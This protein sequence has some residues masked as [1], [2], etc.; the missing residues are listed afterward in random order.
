ME[1]GAFA[2]HLRRMRRVYADRQQVLLAA[3]SRH[4]PDHLRADPDPSG[5]HL[6]C[7]LGPAI[8]TMRD[9][10]IAARAT[11]AGL[12][13]RALSAY[14]P[15]DDGPQGLVLGYAG[16]SADQLEDAIQRLARVLQDGRAPVST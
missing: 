11:Q 13:L 9:T 12:T 14:W 16:F 1:S 2:T 5:M 15:G 8:P 10:Y 4:L 3:L 6:V 7:R